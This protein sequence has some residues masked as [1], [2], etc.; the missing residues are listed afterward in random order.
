MANM[1]AAKERK[2]LESEPEEREPKMQHWFPL[3]LS[4][5]DTRVFGALACKVGMHQW[6]SDS[7]YFIGIANTTEICLFWWQCER[8]G[9]SKLKHITR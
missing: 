3:K 8:C 4:L 2:R 5:W 6:R 1:R 7:D 9:L